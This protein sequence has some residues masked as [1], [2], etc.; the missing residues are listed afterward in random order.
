MFKNKLFLLCQWDWNQLSQ[1]SK[2]PPMRLQVVG[3]ERT[4]DLDLLEE[5]VS[6]VMVVKIVACIVTCNC[7]YINIYIYSHPNKDN[8]KSWKPQKYLINI[9]YTILQTCC[10][11]FWGLPCT[12]DSGPLCTS[13]PHAV[14]MEARPSSLM[15]GFINYGYS[16]IYP[17]VI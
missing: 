16:M 12:Y 17:L 1:E 8:Y 3:H 4:S 6:H 14:L 13:M 7:I 15:I 9:I 11:S 2:Q 10:L 5:T